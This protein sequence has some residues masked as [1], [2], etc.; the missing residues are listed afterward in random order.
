[1]FFKTAIFYI[2]TSSA[3]FI[4]WGS[5][6][7]FSILLILALSFF[8]LKAFNALNFS[9]STLTPSHQFDMLYF[10]FHSDQNILS[11]RFR[12]LLWP[13]GYVDIHCLTSI[14]E[15]IS[16]EIW[17]HILNYLY[18]YEFV[19]VCFMTQNMVY[20]CACFICTWE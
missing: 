15:V 19:K 9:L 8:S 1:M 14:W 20:L 18:S 13:V 5:T 2:L 12:L 7:S 17:R 10:Q 11:F 4:K 3:D 6:P 16:I